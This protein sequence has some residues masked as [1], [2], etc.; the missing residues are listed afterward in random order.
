MEI[1]GK[2]QEEIN[3]NVLRLFKQGW[4]VHEIAKTMH[5]EDKAIENILDNGTFIIGHIIN[6]TLDELKEIAKTGEVFRKYPKNTNHALF[7]F[8]PYMEDLTIDVEVSNLGHIKIN[9]KIV[10]PFEKEKG[11]FYVILQDKI[12]E[13]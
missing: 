7:T 1:K 6:Y 8:R 10:S 4:N 3:T 2:T 12:P 5:L 13:Y 9:D 11:Y